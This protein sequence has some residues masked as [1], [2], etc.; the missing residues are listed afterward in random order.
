MDRLQP[1][2][3]GLNIKSVHW[4]PHDRA[5]NVQ[6]M[7]LKFVL[8]DHSASWMIWW[9]GEPVKEAVEALK[10]IGVDSLVFDPCSNPPDQGDFLSTMR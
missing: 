1:R 10:T 6:M 9:E 4:E 2:C 7:E 8:R 3:Q 5:T